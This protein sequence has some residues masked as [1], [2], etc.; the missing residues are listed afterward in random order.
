MQTEEH[1]LENHMRIMVYGLIFPSHG[2]PRWSNSGGIFGECVGIHKSPRGGAGPHWK[3]IARDPWL[4]SLYGYLWIIW[5]NNNW[6]FS[7]IWPLFQQ[8]VRGDMACL[9]PAACLSNWTGFLHLGL[10]IKSNIFLICLLTTQQ[11]LGW[12]M[13]PQ[14]LVAASSFCWSDG[15]SCWRMQRMTSSSSPR[16]SRRVFSSSRKFTGHLALWFQRFRATLLCLILCENN[17]CSGWTF[18]LRSLLRLC[19]RTLLPKRI[20]AKRVSSNTKRS[21][22]WFE[23]WLTVEQCHPL[24]ARENR[25][26]CTAT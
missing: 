22:A 6:P 11:N 23:K 13:G 18:C 8:K 20:C 12:T 2:L 7:I 4:V 26:A 19:R 25:F 10:V 14:S 5:W 15:S 24:T 16:R 9:G 17:P 21:L 1:N 3:K